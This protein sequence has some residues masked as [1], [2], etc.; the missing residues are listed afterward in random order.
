M[1]VF[2]QI[3]QLVCIWLVEFVSLVQ[4]A[5]AKAVH[6]LITFVHNVLIT[7]EFRAIFVLLAMILGV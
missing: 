6:P 7:M 1:Q 2:A 5:I 3:V 4:L